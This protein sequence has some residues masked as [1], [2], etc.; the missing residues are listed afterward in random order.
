MVFCRNMKWFV[1]SLLVCCSVMLSC[2]E[3]TQEDDAKKK[4]KEEKGQFYRNTKFHDIA[5]VRPVN[6]KSVKNIVLMIGDGMG[7]GQIFSGIV[8]N[9][10]HLNVENTTHIGFS[11]TSSSDNYITDSAAGATALAAGVKTY[12]GAIGVDD[13]KRPLKTI[14]EI[15]EEKGLATGLIS[16]SSIT[17]ATPAS[18]IAHQPSRKMDEEIAADFLKIDID[19]FIGGG[20]K[21]FDKERRKDGRDL[22]GQLKKN[23]YSVADDMDGMNKVT[24]GKLVALLNV[25]HM[26]RYTERREMLLPATLKALEILNQNKNG[27][28]LMIE[29]SQIDWGGHEN[30]TGYIVEEMLSFDRTVGKVLEFAQKDGETLVVI[31]ADHET[32]GFSVTKGNHQGELEGKFVTLGHTPVMV[33]V[34]SYGPQS[35]RFK[36]FYENTQIFFKM[37]EAWTE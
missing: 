31:T 12:N 37:M 10:G 8:A 1:S 26:P 6:G 7:V 35:E 21:F 33:P 28:F 9:K 5:A 32:G 2:V 15:A 23:G 11:K 3:N 14:L 4:R 27:F 18:F 22:L 29:G 30:D 24:S 13:D 25:G 20:R 19:V 36:G 17:H 16:T 34:F